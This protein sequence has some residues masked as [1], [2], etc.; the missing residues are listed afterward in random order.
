[1]SYF[2]DVIF[3][4]TY[5]TIYMTIIAKAKTVTIKNSC[6]RQP[7][8]EGLYGGTSLNS[9]VNLYSMTNLC[10]AVI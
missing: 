3:P 2:Y 8:T 7:N 9:S 1:M 4:P 5:K 10:Y 6:T